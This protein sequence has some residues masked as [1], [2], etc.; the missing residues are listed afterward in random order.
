MPPTSRTFTAPSKAIQSIGPPSADHE[1]IS[2]KV[3]R[4][5]RPAVS[6]G[7]GNSLLSPSCRQDAVMERQ[8]MDREDLLRGLTS[9]DNV[10][11]NSAKTDRT[12][13]RDSDT[14]RR[15]AVL[16]SPVAH[17]LSP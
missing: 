13:F 8:G 16:G 10:V 15:G 6:R 7:G 9:T 12:D 11:R 2:G 17:S 14:G 3:D 4:C 5:A 1:R